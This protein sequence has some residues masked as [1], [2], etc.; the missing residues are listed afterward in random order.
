[1]YMI[2]RKKGEILIAEAAGRD[3]KYLE[4]LNHADL[5]AV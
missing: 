2:E 4:A 1:M 5:V 3:Q